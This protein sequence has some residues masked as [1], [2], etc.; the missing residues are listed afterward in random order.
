MIIRPARICDVPF[1]ATLVNGFAAKG[2]MLPRTLNSLYEELR[3]YTVME[4]EDSIVACAALQ[5]I[6]E[7]W[8]EIRSIAVQAGTHNHGRGSALMEYL[9]KEAKAL[10]LSRVFVLT[11]RPD[12]FTKFGFKEIKKERLPHKVWRD[13]L[14]CV[15]FPDHCDETAMLKIVR[16]RSNKKKT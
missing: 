6:W 16:R 11:L 9:L 13:C 4:E 7:D 8:G 1:I 10:E 5:V 3:N 12:F 2:A 15:K 14:N